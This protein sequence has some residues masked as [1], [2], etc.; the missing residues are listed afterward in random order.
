[1]QETSEGEP[2]VP[3]S[4]VYFWIPT[5]SHTFPTEH[6]LILH[7]VHGTDGAHTPQEPIL[8]SDSACHPF[9]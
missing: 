7:R 4:F 3:C 1:M 6:Q 8:L 9:M 2:F 5:H